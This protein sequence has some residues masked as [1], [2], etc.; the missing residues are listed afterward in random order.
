MVSKEVPDWTGSRKEPY[1]KKD[2]MHMH[3]PDS[4]EDAEDDEI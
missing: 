4:N 1:G 2:L 3:W